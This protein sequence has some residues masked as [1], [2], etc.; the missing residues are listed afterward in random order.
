MTS[1]TAAQTTAENS[2]STA[3]PQSPPSPSSPDGRLLGTRVQ[4]ERI[5]ALK[6]NPARPKDAPKAAAVAASSLIQMPPKPV[7]SDKE[8]MRAEFDRIER[9]KTSKAAYISAGVPLRH[10]DPDGTRANEFRK[11]EPW[12]AKAQCL[13]LLRGKGIMV[14]LIG[15][16]GTGKTQLAVDLIRQQCNAGGWAKYCRAMEFFG[17]IKSAWKKDGPDED[18]MVKRFTRP[19]LLV[20][21]EAQVRS[22]SKWE[23]DQLTNMV[24]IR[25]GDMKDT[26][27]I[28]NLTAGEFEKSIGESIYSRLTET[29]GVIVCD[30]QSFRGKE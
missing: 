25:Y 8:K 29:G 12:Q 15:K 4:A 1:A 23:N 18:E 19:G 28:A 2:N 30:W 22:E 7:S 21:D 10:A 6:S 14:A 17:A 26:I 11:C 9:E 16:R 13:S 24:D 20:I 5:V 3:S 27:F